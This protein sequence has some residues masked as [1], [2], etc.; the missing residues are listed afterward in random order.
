MKGIKGIERKVWKKLLL[1]RT[2]VPFALVSLLQVSLQSD[3]R[4]NLL[5][6]AEPMPTGSVNLKISA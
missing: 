6:V 4:G 2:S 1:G 5:F 3:S